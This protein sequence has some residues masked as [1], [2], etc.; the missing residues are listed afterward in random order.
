MT[1]GGVEQRRRMLFDIELMYLSRW[2]S[3]F[4]QVISIILS[5]VHLSLCILPFPPLLISHPSRDNLFF[6]FLVRAGVTIS[7]HNFDL[8][9]KFTF[10]FLIL[11]IYLSEYDNFHQIVQFLILKEYSLRPQK[12]EHNYLFDRPQ[13]IEHI[14]LWKVFNK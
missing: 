1:M 9:A 12:I 14:Y 13:K 2:H 5:Q 10:F 4:I 8:F 6:L 7:F 3:D 11:F